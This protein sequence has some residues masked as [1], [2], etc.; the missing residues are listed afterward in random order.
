MCEQNL[1]VPFPLYAKQP[2]INFVPSSIIYKPKIDLQQTTQFPNAIVTIIYEYANFPYWEMIIVNYLMLPVC[3]RYVFHLEIKQMRTTKSWE[4]EADA[5][6]TIL[7]LLSKHLAF[8]GFSRCREEWHFRVA[9]YHMAKFKDFR[10]DCIESCNLAWFFAQ[11]VFI[12][13]E[14]KS[15]LKQITIPGI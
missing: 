12:F 13:M 10:S 3:T 2:Q 15:I 5:I 8:F 14:N 11:F 1:V 4:R 6:T 7:T 9:K